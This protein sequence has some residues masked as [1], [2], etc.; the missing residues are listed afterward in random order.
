MMLV[1]VLAARLAHPFAPHNG[2]WWTI[3]PTITL[4]IA[5]LTALYLYAVGPLRQR[6][7]WAARVE[8][9]QVALFLLAMV[10]MLVALQGPL[11]ELSEYYLFSAHMAQH[12][13]V[14]LIMPPLLLKGTPEWLI[15][16]I[17]AVPGVLPIMRVLTNPWFAFAAFNIVFALWHVPA[18]YQRALGNPPVHG[19]E[20]I[21]FM[22]AAVLTWWP[23]FSPTARL[24]RL[25]DP[26]S[27]FYLFVQSLIPT[28]LGAIIT[29][30]NISLYPYYAA[31]PR[32]TWL[33]PAD[34]QQAAGLLMWLGGASIVLFVLTIRFFRWINL[35]SD[36]DLQPSHI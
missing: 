36:D 17:L 21:L 31:A 28:I 23:I 20:H 11:H 4:G 14:T 8:E 35:E 26:V 33:S 29:F 9:R 19:L 12:L 22:G 1:A 10:I 30:A 5:G 27:I 6:F 2:S 16:K 32:V 25:S 13:L 18:L 24:P 7:V 15:D 3:D 34:D